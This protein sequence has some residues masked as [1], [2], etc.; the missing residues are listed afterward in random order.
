VRKTPHPTEG[1]VIIGLVLLGPELT[2]PD[3]VPAAR[4]AAIAAAARRFL[5]PTDWPRQIGVFDVSLRA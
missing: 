1:W 3:G 4:V 5:M 2:T